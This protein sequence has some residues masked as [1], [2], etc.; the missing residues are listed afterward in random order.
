M[1]LSLSIIVVVS[2]II[3]AL[4]YLVKKAIHAAS[5]KLALEVLRQMKYSSGLISLKQMDFLIVFH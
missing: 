1:S 3:N 5:A 2:N 4:E